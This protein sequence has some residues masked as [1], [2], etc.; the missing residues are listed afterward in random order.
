VGGAG[1]GRISDEPFRVLDAFEHEI[2]ETD[3]GTTPADAAADETATTEPD[4]RPGDRSTTRR[5]RWRQ[6]VVAQ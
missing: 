5:Q 4:H 6:N 3:G 1:T 2:G